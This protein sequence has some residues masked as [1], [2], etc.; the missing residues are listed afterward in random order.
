MCADHTHN[1][2]LIIRHISKYLQRLCWIIEDSTLEFACLRTSADN[3][4]NSLSQLNKGANAAHALH[5]VEVNYD[6]L[7]PADNATHAEML[8]ALA[9]KEMP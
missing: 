1:A 5:T 4:A 7:L 9:D 3:L 8:N 2:N 6:M